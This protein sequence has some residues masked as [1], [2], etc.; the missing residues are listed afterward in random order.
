MPISV[1]IVPS[2]DMARLQTYHSRCAERDSSEITPPPQ[3]S[4]TKIWGPRARHK[5]RKDS[6]QV[7]QSQHR[8]Q[9]PQPHKPTQT[10]SL[11]APTLIIRK[12]VDSASTF[13]VPPTL[14][15]TSPHLDK[16]SIAILPPR[17]MHFHPSATYPKTASAIWPAP[18]I[19]PSDS[20]TAH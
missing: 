16:N 11:C 14:S 4:T 17:T 12:P 20:P 1:V 10:H 13:H 7:P 9:E 6:A 2:L 3:S 15:S 5:T 19:L 18:P 8:C